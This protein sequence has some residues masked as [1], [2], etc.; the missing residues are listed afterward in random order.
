MMRQTAVSG[1]APTPLGKQVGGMLLP[2]WPDIEALFY[3]GTDYHVGAPS[4]G[5]FD[6][7]RIRT[8]GGKEGFVPS[9]AVRSPITPR[10]QF[11]LREG[12]WKLVVLD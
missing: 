12:T 9:Q 5:A 7:V 10:A 1:T 8:A 2:F 3:L 4:A 6:W 11:A